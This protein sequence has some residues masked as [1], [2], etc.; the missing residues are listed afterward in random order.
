MQYLELYRRMFLKILLL[1]IIIIFG[2]SP[3]SGE[4]AKYDW[5]P[6]KGPHLNGIS[7]ESDWDTEFLKKDIRI[8]WKRDVGDGYSNVTIV[9]D[10]LYTMG[11]HIVP[12]RPLRTNILFCLKASTGKVVWKYTLKVHHGPWQ[13]TKA[14]PV[15]SDGL[16]YS[17]T[18]DGNMLCNDA[19]T[20]KLIWRNNVIK[21]FSALA[22]KWTFASS[23]HIEG[24]IAVAS[25]CRNGIAV[26]KKTGSVVW[27][28]R[29]GRGSYSTPVPY[30]CN[31][32]TYL[33]IFGSGALYGVKALTGEVAWEYPWETLDENAADPV[34]LGDKIF[35]SSGYDK[36]CALLDISSGKAKLLWSNTYMRSHIASAI[37][38]GDYIYGIDGDPTKKTFL[39]CLNLKDGSLSWKSRQL[40]ITNMSS[41]N[42]YLIM[43]DRIGKLYVVEANP[44]YYREIASKKVLKQTDNLYFTAPVLCRSTLYFRGG[45]SDL[46]SIDISG[47]S[48][49]NY[50]IFIVIKDKLHSL[51][52]I[53][54]DFF[55]RLF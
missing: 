49:I 53:I 34:I 1:S 47:Q 12:K 24:D 5:N 36:G 52:L 54:M 39:V 15:Y 10:F 48:G 45:M 8:K 27:K 33:A 46:Y 14:T 16:V 55:D 43:L 4:P 9:G 18:Q 44:Y 40:G 19:Y 31:G 13:L 17:L 6:W 7:D 3:V 35:I 11:F 41:A 22:P 37:I 50:N 20:G 32:E 26:N 23:V 25:V 42:G 29:A 28:S 30:G 21:D 51:L 2:C 38:I